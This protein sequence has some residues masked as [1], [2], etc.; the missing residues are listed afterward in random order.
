MDRGDQSCRDNYDGRPEAC[1]KQ[2]R[3]EVIFRELVKVDLSF[4]GVFW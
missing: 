3:L 1:G 2:R 4:F